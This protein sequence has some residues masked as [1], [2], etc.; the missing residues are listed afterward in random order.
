MTGT[1]QSKPNVLWDAFVKEY[2]SRILDGLEPRTKD[3]ALGSLAHYKWLMKPVKVHVICTGHVD[4]F[5]SKRRKEPASGRAKCS[6]GKALW[7]DVVGRGR[8]M[9]RVEIRWGDTP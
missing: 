9:S 1:Y 8:P 2:T 4:E 3:N 6:R 7:L 5:A